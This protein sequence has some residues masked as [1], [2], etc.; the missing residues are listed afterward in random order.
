MHGHKLN[1]I[2]I[3]LTNSNNKS[4]SLTITDVNGDS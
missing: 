4:D 3:V 2:V 1:M